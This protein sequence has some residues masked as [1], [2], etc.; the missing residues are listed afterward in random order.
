MA[1]ENFQDY[2]YSKWENVWKVDSLA[3]RAISRKGDVLG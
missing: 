3:M 2:S 1:Y